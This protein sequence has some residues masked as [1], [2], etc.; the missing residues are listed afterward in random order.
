MP[1]SPPDSHGGPPV[2]SPETL[3]QGAVACKVA[4]WTPVIPWPPHRFRASFPPNA[5]TRLS[6]ACERGPIHC[7]LRTPEP[8]VGH[9]SAHSIDPHW[10][11]WPSDCNSGLVVPSLALSCPVQL[12][13]GH[14]G[15]CL[16]MLARYPAVLG[17]VWQCR[18]NAA[19]Q[20]FRHTGCKGPTP[21]IVRT[22]FNNGSMRGG[23]ARIHDGLHCTRAWVWCRKYR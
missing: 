20:H 16:V 13:P 2:N 8:S 22:G 1:C 7:S 21:R 17:T 15:P 19:A 23:G 14:C 5:R 6:L 4:A 11:F 18:C 9:G 3:P 12:F 10:P